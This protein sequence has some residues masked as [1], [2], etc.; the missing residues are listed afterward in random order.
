MKKSIYTVFAILS[1]VL[2]AG[3]GDFLEQ[4]PKDQ[5]YVTEIRDLDEMLV[6]DGYMPASSGTDI[7]YWIHVMDDDMTFTTSLASRFAACHF[8]WWEP[9][10][11]TENTWTTFYKRI[12]ITNAVLFDIDRFAD[13]GD[14]YRRIKGEALFLRA[15]YYY[16]LVNLYALPY[17]QATASTGMGVPLKLVPTIEDRRFSR[18][19]LGEC[20]DRIAA[21]LDQAAKIMEG[22]ARPGT[23]YRASEMAARVLLSRVYLYMGRWQD[24]ADQCDA[25][26]GS[27][28]Y[29][30]LD[31]NG[32][33]NNGNA[34]YLGSP[35]TIFTNGATTT[36]TQDFM[37]LGDPKFRISD[38]AF[39]LYA[40]T[41]RRKTLFLRGM[42]Y[43]GAA[44]AYVQK[45]S[46]GLTEKCSDYFMLR[47]PEAY[48]NRA[49]ALAMLDRDDDAARD[50]QT[51]R[52]KRFTTDA[53]DYNALSG[54]ELVNAIRDERRREFLFE[55][56]RW[57][58][59]RRY[60]VSPKWP[61]QKEI[62]HNYYE[63]TSVSG[64][65]VLGKY[66]QDAAYYV[67]P[68]PESEITLNGGSLRQ[69]PERTLK[70]A[71]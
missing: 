14:E 27:G 16:W 49:E 13:Q 30:L 8:Y 48:L 60:A 66:D 40:A 39:A 38:E 55:G 35:E 20:Y 9:Y 23:P 37:Y 58:D 18:N 70:T 43:M 19:T 54:E 6:G 51:L 25:V 64:Q 17:T 24:A 69:N 3:C 26:I 32:V 44:N 7:N 52:G 46:G 67:L 65:I 15:A 57:F 21:D 1:G 42:A 12:N 71:Q 10:V 45:R 34:V 63:Y 47:L 53:M 2:A 56:Q 50:L 62:R 4:Y 22:L 41:D 11:D 33:A 59:L 31:F 29:S 61:M 5:T 36:L 68:L 28:R